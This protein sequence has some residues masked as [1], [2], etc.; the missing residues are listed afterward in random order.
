MGKI[1]NI[2]SLPN[3][4]DKPARYRFS[5]TDGV[6]VANAM[7]STQLAVRIKAGEIVENSIVTLT[8]Y[9]VNLINSENGL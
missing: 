5:V 4:G 7:A 6:D 3:Q 1:F 2:K 9:Q 8:N